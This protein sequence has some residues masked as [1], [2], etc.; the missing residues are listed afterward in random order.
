MSAA[1]ATRRTS[2]IDQVPAL[3]AERAPSVTPGFYFE[4]IA[5]GHGTEAWLCGIC[6]TNVTTTPCPQHN[7]N[8]KRDI[9]GARGYYEVWKKGN[10]KRYGSLGG[11]CGVCDRGVWSAPCTFCAPGAVERIQV[12]ELFALGVRREVS[13]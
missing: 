5:K 6:G 9:T 8:G 10:G 11:R 7:V 12:R 3:L 2:I 1:V 4:V 13:R